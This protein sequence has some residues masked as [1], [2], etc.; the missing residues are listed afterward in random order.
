MHLNP[1]TENPN[2]IT[3][4]VQA[5][6]NPQGIAQKIKN[7]ILHLE[8]VNNSLKATVD[9]QSHD[10]TQLRNENNQ[11]KTQLETIQIL[12]KTLPEGT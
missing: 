6:N 5:Q 2:S 9:K 1:T 10:I 4:P 7:L 11:L 3:Q 12:S 8:S